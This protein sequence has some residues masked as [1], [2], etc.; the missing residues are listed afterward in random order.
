M[1][2]AQWRKLIP[3]ARVTKTLPDIDR[4]QGKPVFVN[5][6]FN[7]T[8]IRAN[9]NWSQVLVHWDDSRSELWYGRLGIEILDK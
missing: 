8:V 4:T 9:S 5:K 3:G 7:G 6:V 2:K 1:T